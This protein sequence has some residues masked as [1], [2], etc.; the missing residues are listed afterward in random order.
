[1]SILK[2]RKNHHHKTN[3][4]L[5]YTVIEQDVETIVVILAGARENFYEKLKRYMKS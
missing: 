2:L 4:G 3:Y 1:L 5:A